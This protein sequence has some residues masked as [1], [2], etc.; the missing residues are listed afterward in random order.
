MVAALLVAGPCQRQ[1]SW[2]DRLSAETHQRPNGFPAAAGSPPT[3]VSR[4]RTTTRGREKVLR[5]LVPERTLLPDKDPG[6]WREWAVQDPILGSTGSFGDPVFL[7]QYSYASR[8]CSLALSAIRAG[9]VFSI[10]FCRAGLLA[11]AAGPQFRAPPS[12]LPGHSP[13]SPKSPGRFHRCSPACQSQAMRGRWVAETCHLPKCLE[14]D[15]ALR[16]RAALC[17]PS[18]RELRM[19]LSSSNPTRAC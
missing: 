11:C 5:V 15:Q 2:L 9:V 1:P 7:A 13:R 18:S 16:R 19:A 8:T 4:P 3:L 6:W 17:D 14:L 12:S 10:R